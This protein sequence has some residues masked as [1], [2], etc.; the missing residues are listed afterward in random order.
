MSTHDKIAPNG[1]LA[2]ALANVGRYWPEHG[3]TFQDLTGKETHYPFPEL[4]RV[5][6]ARA[7]ALQELGLGKGDRMGL[8]LIEPEDFV[9]TFLGAVRAGII[10][11]PLYPPVALGDLDNYVDKITSILTTAGA[12][13]LVVS[14]KLKNLLWS[15]VDKV[16]SLKRL[17]YVERL[18][19]DADKATFPEIGPDDIC[20][21]QYTS[22]STST[23]KGVIVT[24]G[25]LYANCKGIMGPGLEMDASRDVAVSWLPLYHD[26]GLIGFVISPLYWGVPSVFIPTLRF[27][28]RPNCWMET[29]HAKGATSTFAPPFALGLAVRRSRPADLERWDLSRLRFVG[30]GAEPIS[31]SV[32]RQFTDHFHEHCGMRREAVLPAYGMA[33]ATLAIGLKPVD[34]VFRT[35]VVDKEVFQ[36]EGRAIPAESGRETLEHVACG[37]WFP[38][39][40]VAVMDADGTVL[41]EG[42]E[43]ELCFRGP[44]VAPGYFG[45]PEATAEAFRDGW[46]HTGDLGYVLDGNVYVTGRMKD[47]IIVNGRNYHPQ[48]I[49]WPV[50]AIEGV[51]PGNVVAFSIPGETTEEVVIALEARPERPED[52]AAR[53]AD[54]V[55]D[56]FSLSVKEVVVL[57]AGQL[58]KTSSGKL[59]RRRTRDLYLQR[60][61]GRSGNRSA[62]ATGDKVN[63]ARHMASSLITRVKHRLRNGD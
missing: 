57:E 12:T 13:E 21:L 26:M 56:H 39:H 54:T 52:L 46:L 19:G 55:K 53:V 7:H 61:L 49:E 51:R 40:D 36:A 62:G 44:S 41:P 37:G 33:E 17:S 45:N 8:V 10:P 30:V 1:T 50:A 32:V 14:E 47:L 18:E 28:K 22:G 25:N 15:L 42:R 60:K 58:P 63:L 20:F 35:R 23:P 48:S 5:T 34:E 16:P 11:V 29:I 4:D 6:A 38:E 9:V 43:G 3:Y 2:E 31:A 27:L 24:H 59:Q